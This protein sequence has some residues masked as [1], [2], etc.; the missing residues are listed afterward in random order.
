VMVNG[1]MPWNLTVTQLPDFLSEC[2]PN[3][4]VGTAVT[5]DTVERLRELTAEPAIE[6]REL[7]GAWARVR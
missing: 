2:R 4:I 3:A 7:R 6:G 5:R 1:P